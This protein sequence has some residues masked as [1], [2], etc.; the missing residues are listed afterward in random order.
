M[1]AII[2]TVVSAVAGAFEGAEK[3]IAPI[4]TDAVEH[5]YVT[6]KTERL[7]QLETLISTSPTAD[8]ASELG[9]FVV[10][11]CTDAG[12]PTGQLGPDISVPLDVIRALCIIAVDSIYNTNQ[13]LA[14]GKAQ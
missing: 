4:T 1:S 7:N 14:S 12:V 3:I 2:G 5:K 13:G 8:R 6:S 9:S 11:L 10:Q